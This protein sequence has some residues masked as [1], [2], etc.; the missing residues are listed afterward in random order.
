[1]LMEMIQKK[2]LCQWVITLLLKKWNKFNPYN[3]M[4]SK[5]DKII[6]LWN[7]KT[8]ESDEVSFYIHH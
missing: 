4:V 3:T 2:Q 8:K 6:N 7:S 1:M 5:W